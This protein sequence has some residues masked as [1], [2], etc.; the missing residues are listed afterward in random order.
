M[1]CRR[2]RIQSKERKPLKQAQNSKDDVEHVVRSERITAEHVQNATPRLSAIC[3]LFF[4]G[5]YQEA[6][7]SQQPSIARTLFNAYRESVHYVDHGRVPGF[8]FKNNIPYMEMKLDGPQRMGSEVQIQFYQEAG[9]KT[10]VFMGC[11]IGEIELG[12][13]SEAQ[14]NLEMEMKNWF[15]VD[16][17]RQ[18]APRELQAAQTTNQNTSS[19]SSLRSLSIGNVEYSPSIFNIPNEALLPETL[20]I[21]SVPLSAAPIISINSPHDQAKH[22]LSQIRNVQFPTIENEDSIMTKAILDVLT[23]PA[24][25]SSSQMSTAQNSPTAFRSYHA[26]FG[27]RVATRNQKH[28][29]FKRAVLFFRNLNMRRRRELHIRENRPNTAMQLHHVIS[30]RRR[31]QKLNESFQVLRSFLPP[32]SKK[33]KASVL[34]NT[35]EYLSSLKSQLKEVRKRNQTLETQLST[36]RIEV[37]LISSSRI[38]QRV[39]VEISQVLSASTSESRLL[40]LRVNLRSGECSLLDLV[41][42]VLGFLKQQRNIS[43]LSV[44]SNTRMQVESNVPVHGLVLR[45]KIE[46]D[47]FDESGF[48]EA[49]RRVVDDLPH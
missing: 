38:D 26:A 20:I 29:M 11:T 45:L 13:S 37:G 41:F 36:N 33:D 6:E 47:E 27:P 44:Q 8:A 4:D 35:T 18:T 32:G 14:V 16:F 31:R 40:D 42:R 19:S 12:M 24:S 34:S 46:G 39:N 9:I 43:L 48:Q 28:N 17:S 30:E 3:L 23:S 49:V 22:A 25:T 7:S 21:K 10:V 2:S 5:L 1:R 15:P